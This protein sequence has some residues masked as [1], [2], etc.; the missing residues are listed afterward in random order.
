MKTCARGYGLIMIQP[1]PP[2]ADDTRP[3][4]PAPRAGEPHPAAEP[5]TFT[6]ADVEHGAAEDLDAAVEG[7]LE[8]ELETWDGFL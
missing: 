2:V 3:S 6:F 5:K 4:V 7:D 8:A 1:V